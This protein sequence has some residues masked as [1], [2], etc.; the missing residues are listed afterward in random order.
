MIKT[1]MR[2]S[3]L[4]VSLLLLSLVCL[5]TACGGT[6]ASTV[7][8]AST[9]APKADATPAA[10]NASHTSSAASQ[11]SVGLDVKA[12][13]PFAT[14]RMLDQ[15]HGWALSKSAVF[16]T[17]DGGAHWTNVASSKPI[18]PGAVAT[19]M[20]IDHA[21]IASV[22]SPEVSNT[23]DI[24]RTSDG[25]QSWQHSSFTDDAVGVADPPKFV[26]PQ[27][28]WIEIINHGGPGAGNE[29]AAIYGTKDGGQTWSKLV[30]SGKGFGLPGFKT[31]ISFK[32]TL[33]GWATGHDA[34]NNAL[35]YVTH[36]GGKSWRPQA[37]PDLPG[38]IGTAETSVSFQ[39]TPPVFFGNNGLLPVQVS[40]QIEANKPLHGTVLYITNDGGNTW[41]SY[42][43]TQPAT[44]SPFGSD[45]LYIVNPQ[46]AWASD[47]QSGIIYGTVD[48]GK[49]WQK[50]SNSIGS[51]KAFSFVDNS[52]GWAI[53]DKA[54]WRTRDGARTWQQVS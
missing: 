36:D 23:V 13:G 17:S 46:H 38:A 14:I 2:F 21:W 27:T 39:T 16:K 8:A 20:D 12:A 43:K 41:F 18:I 30:E 33:N 44:L 1:T 54:L 35:L 15:L 50:V 6:G 48:G 25:G 37:L 9:P 32:D 7:D 24:L 11:A 40:G 3:S 29:S 10:T 51:I 22:S 52:N 42:W 53:T 4:G 28:G 19:F 49:S 34:S 26:N 5:L 45:N 47:S 31:G